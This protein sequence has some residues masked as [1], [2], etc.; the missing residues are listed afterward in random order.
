MSSFYIGYLPQA[1]DDLR[2]FLR[3]VI[4]ALASFAVALAIILVLAQ[5][6]FSAAFFEFTKVRNFTGT[7]QANPYPTL[8]VID[9]TSQAPTQYLLAAVGKHGFT[10]RLT[11]LTG[12][13]VRLRAKLIYRNEGAMLEV[14]PNSIAPESITDSQA[15]HTFVEQGEDVTLSGEIVD[16]K[17]FLGVMNPGRTKV[18]R[19][20]AARCLSGGI[21]PALLVQDGTSS[22]LYPLAASD[23][24]KLDPQHFLTHAGEPVTV[25]GKLFRSAT[26]LRLN[27]SQITPN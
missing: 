21:P 10:E 9:P 22:T 8:L 7:L 15:A 18:H 24:A 6:K 23:G 26:S 11:E 12:K 25:R 17:C 2:K 14:V 1:P 27:V 3:R 20:C 4:T 19:D 16:T 13:P 5:Q